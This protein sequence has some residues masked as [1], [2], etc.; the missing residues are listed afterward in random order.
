MP[1]FY[2]DLVDQHVILRYSLVFAAFVCLAGCDNR[3]AMRQSDDVAAM[4]AAITQIAPIGS[5]VET[6]TKAME[7][8]GFSCSPMVSSP[9]AGVEGL[10]DFAY[11]VNDRAF[12]SAQAGSVYRRWQAA[13]VQENGTIT[14][15]RVRT[16]LVGP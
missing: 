11:C 16:G 14:E 15:I 12:P 5:S 4:Q 3:L 9:W 8:E 1:R 13:L 6:G 2:S 7:R 10:S